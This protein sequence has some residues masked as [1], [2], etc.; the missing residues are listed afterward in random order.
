MLMNPKAPDATPRAA[1]KPRW[2]YVGVTPAQARRQGLG[3]LKEKDAKQVR[4]MHTAGPQSMPAA[5]RKAAPVAPAKPRSLPKATGTTNTPARPRSTPAVARYK[6]LATPAKS[7]KPF[8]GG[9]PRSARKSVFDSPAPVSK[10]PFSARK[11]VISTPLLKPPYDPRTDP[12]PYEKKFASATDIADRVA[13][14]NSEDRKRAAA[15]LPIKG[16]GEQKTPSKSRGQ[17]KAKN[18][19]EEGQEEKSSTP[20]GS[21]TKL[22][23][24]SPTKPPQSRFTPGA[25]GALTPKRAAPKIPASKTPAPATPL[26]KNPALRRILPK[27]TPR[28]PVLRQLMDPNAFRT[29]SKEIE[30]S[31]DKAIDRKIAEDARSGKEFT[32]SGNRV[33]ELLEARKKG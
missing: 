22:P 24:R 17:E 3:V 19:A 13:E 6:P 31:L 21:P 25:P 33:K 14:W 18:S 2:P 1:H 32:P 23:L 7:N 28:T 15:E 4:I 10:P 30:S 9:I 26:P 20:E 16:R 11:S 27:P 5:S 8:A 12:R 29:P